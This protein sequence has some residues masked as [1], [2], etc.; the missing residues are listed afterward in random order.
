MKITITI[1]TQA[2]ASGPT[3][4]QSTPMSIWIELSAVRTTST[5]TGRGCSATA[6]AGAFSSVLLSAAVTSPIVCTARRSGL[7]SCVFSAATRA[8]RLLRYFG[9]DPARSRNWLD[10][11]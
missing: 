1:T 5:F 9:S 3:T 4:G 11:R 2:L 7:F 8:M 6:G 10:T